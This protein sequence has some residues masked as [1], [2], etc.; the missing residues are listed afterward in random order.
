MNSM[1]K[2]LYFLMAMMIMAFALPSGAASS[3]E[4]IFSV[5]GIPASASVGST[6][7]TV[8]FKNET[9]TGNST[10][11][12]TRLIAPTGWTLSNPIAIAGGSVQGGNGTVEAGG[13]SVS[14]VNIPTIKAGGNTWI[15]QVTAAVPASASCSNLWSAQAYTGNSLG[16]DEF[17]LVNSPS[18]LTTNVVVGQATAF[19]TQ[20]TNTTVGH[21][22][23]VA[24]ALTTACGAGPANAL[25]TITVPGCTV[26]SGC[27]SGST[28]TTDATGTATFAALKIN[29][30]GTYQ[31]T[32]STPGFPSTISQSFTVY[33]GILNC[34]DS[35][36]SNF[37]NP[38]NLASD[39][40]GYAAGSR[41][42]YNKDGV[43][44]GCVPVPYT[45]TNN[46]LTDDQVHLFWDVGIQPN[47]AFIYTLNWR[48]RPVDSTN[49]LTGWTTA[50][51]PGVAWLTTLS[52]AP[53]FV[54]GLACLSGKLPAPY[55]TLSAAIDVNATSI[56]II[57][58]AA[59][60]VT[61][62]PA[63]PATP[64]PIVIPSQVNPIK[65]ERLTATVLTSQSP[66]TSAGYA[67]TYTLTYTVTRG[68]ATE[69]FSALTSHAAGAMV[70]STPLPI[71]PNDATSFPPPYTVLRQAN[72]C[73]AEHGWNAFAIG[74]SGNTQ[75]LYFT[76]VI[77]LGDGWVG[78]L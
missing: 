59:V 62:A 18:G 25:V 72:M 48:L 9:P 74:A 56:T 76:T 26:A 77:D 70:V 38:G 58:V 4:K 11:N 35:F 51:R 20:P 49:P 64:F 6:T 12:S 37:V 78:I 21:V 17:R 36:A 52:G 65:T 44:L 71:I 2:I 46:I 39:Q 63:V 60:P 33:E 30:F 67:G 69:G 15:M 31:L 73:I 8:T 1:R 16:G 50:P 68:G 3:P 43:S 47:A 24:V 66:A 14:F 23:P 53:I 22:I 42:K 45:F 75:L 19:T 10:I 34:G 28:A 40:P 5:S 13:A 41:G 61:G 55:G 54:P 57:G 27:L 29:S 7:V 32:A